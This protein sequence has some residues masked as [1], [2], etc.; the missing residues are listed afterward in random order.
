MT[1]PLSIRLFSRGGEMGQLMRSIDWS[2]TGLGPVEGWPSSLRTALGIVLGSRFPMLL[3]WGEDL[4]QLYNDAYRPILGAKHPQSLAAPGAQ[5]WS[6]VWGILGPLAEG[7]QRGG[8]ATWNER[9]LLPMDRKGFRE[10][11]YF[12]FSYSPVPDDQGGVGGVL[13]TC[14]ETTP[15]VLG[16][17]R[18]VTL[19]QISGEA[20]NAKSVRVAALRAMRSLRANPQDL[21]FASLC[22]VDASGAVAE[23]FSSAGEDPARSVARWPLVELAGMDQPIELGTLPPAPAPQPGQATPTRALVVAVRGGAD[24]PTLAY[25]VAGLSAKLEWDERYQGFL[26]LV[27]AHLGR[28]L[29]NARAYEE[30]SRR[31]EVLAELNRAK[32]AFFSNVSHEFRTPLTLMLGPLEDALG[33]GGQPLSPGQRSRLE[34]VQR[35]AV[36]LMRLVNTLLD[37]TRLEAGRVRPAISPVDLGQQTRELVSQFQATLERAGLT[38]VVETPPLPG[39]VYVD[40]QLWE[41]IVLNLVSNAFK[42]TFTGEI[43]VR[44]GARDGHAFLEVRDTGVGIPAEELPRIFQRFHRVEG[45]RGRTIEG[46]GI[47]LALVEEL[48]R[49]HGGTVRAESQLDRGST[50]TVTLPL[51][52]AHLDP[53]WINDGELPRGA[54]QAPAFLHE[55]QQWLE[56]ATPAPPPPAAYEPGGRILVADDNADMRDYIGRLLRD[57][58]WSVE[59]VSDG[60]QALERVRA[61]PPELL[62]TDVM[63]PRLDGFGLLRALRADE[64]TRELPVV[65]LSARAGEERRVEGLEAGAEDYLVKPFAARELLAR[66]NLRVARAQARR[67]EKERRQ[68]LN[69]IFMQ[70]P[71]LIATLRGPEHVF[72]VINARYQEF[73]AGRRLEGLAVV[74]ALPELRGQS[75]LELLH[76]VYQTGE[77]AYGAELPVQVMR[78]GREVQVFFNFVYQA[79]RDREGKV[80]GVLVFAFDVTPQ[81]ESRQRVEL[82]MSEV[83]AADQRKDEFL[84]M[85]AHELRNPLAAISMSLSRMDPQDGD[86]QRVQRHRGVARRQVTNLVRLVDDLLDVSRLSRGR[87]ELRKTPQ[88]LGEIV[89]NAVSATRGMIDERRHAL[90]LGIAAGPFQVLGDPTRLE[91]VVTNLLTNAAKYTEPGGAIR[92]SLGR[93]AGPT[94][95]QSVLKVKD[96]GRGI[97]AQMLDQV[98]DLFVQVD[99]TL[100]RTSGG[101]GL[102]LTVVRRLVELHGGTVEAHS[103]GTGL[104][105]EFVVRLPLAP[106][107]GAAA[108]DTAPVAAP[109][110]PPAVTPRR[111]LVV[112]DSDDIRSTLQEI[113]EELGHEVEVAADGVQGAAMLAARPP[114]LAFVDVGLPG[115]DGYEVARRGRAA[116]GGDRTFLVALTGYGG[117][118]HRQRAQQAGFD[119][120]LTKPLDVDDLP[121]VLRMSRPA[122]C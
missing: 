102:G 62:I 81:V 15:E 105:S 87:I 27:A 113:L 39:P 100:E 104:G 58:G 48:V 109:V 111:I 65:M 25:L 68:L 36:R 34:L 116:P 6:E 26:S 16:E 83:R 82:L 12:T 7:V 19:Q 120:H 17:R 110:L 23:T 10:E 49:L 72:D 118:E 76:R 85:L 56:A 88:A 117:A 97:P 71:A 77:T 90:T 35:N 43:R 30:E 31:V 38:L 54:P 13:V 73:F 70:A 114:D 53:L 51:G 60:A 84:A 57:A 78:D 108:T 93:E 98:F 101:L 94:G 22:L 64:G 28:A 52:K 4:L 50:F 20:S 44:V 11:T 29:D 112:E 79:L 9:L 33:D 1:H 45:A 21:P 115:L 74:K 61:D 37:F 63:M 89:Q 24:G 67:A 5:V 32:T 80:E 91:Q 122:A 59:T 46:S 47:G 42:F 41:K 92:V 14:Q 55:A 103:R 66:V 96:S 8:P 95:A 86:P 69:D 18:L 40:P 3:W 121:A 106:E 75:V 107:A 2:R 99:A 119:L